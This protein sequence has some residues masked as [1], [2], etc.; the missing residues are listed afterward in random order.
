VNR[1]EPVLLTALAATSNSGRASRGWKRTLM[2][3]KV[4]IALDLPVPLK[5]TDEGLVAEAA[6][7]F[8]AFLGLDIALVRT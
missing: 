4:T 3:G 8:G 6:H 5:R 2:K 1:E 7:R